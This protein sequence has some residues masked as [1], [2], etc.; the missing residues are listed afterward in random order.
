MRPVLA[1]GLLM[2]LCAPADA[3]SVHHK[4]PLLRSPAV[5]SQGFQD[6]TASGWSYAAPRPVNRYDDTP[7]YN[8][9]SKFGGGAP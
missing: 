1:L 3:A 6:R 7:S 2:A 5:S 8:D 9:P 4:K